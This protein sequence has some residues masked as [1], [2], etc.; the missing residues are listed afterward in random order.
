[1][2][3]VVPD[4]GRPSCSLFCLAKTTE[5]F[6]LYQLLLL[7]LLVLLQP[8]PP[9]FLSVPFGSDYATCRNF[10]APHLNVPQCA[11]P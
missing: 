3:A 6:C 9:C 5:T 1:M 8:T 4:V 10:I 7:L 11:V 2:S